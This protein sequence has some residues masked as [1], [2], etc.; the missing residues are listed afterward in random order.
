MS[1]NY[2]TEA[3]VLKTRRMGDF[4]KTAVILSPEKGILNAVAH[5]AYKGKSR[6][7]SITDPFCINDFELYHNPVKELWKISGCE[8]KRLF[9]NIRENLNS[10]YNASFWAELILKS[11]AS[12]ADYEWVYKLFTGALECLDR[13]PSDGALLT[14]HFLYRFLAGSGF[15]TDFSEC[16]HCGAGRGN[17]DFYYSA[18]EGCFLC[19]RCGSSALPVIS[20]EA[21]SYLEASLSVS[22]EEAAQKRLDLQSV[23]KTRNLLLA[24]IKSIIEVPLNTLDYID[25]GME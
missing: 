2:R 12:G 8:S 1:R 22:L 14:T 16:G 19:R 24:I 6:I 23:K 17:E 25:Y 21:A 20:G 10:M 15:I 7:S 5:G 4:H 13:R 3:V 18:L 11:H 9:S